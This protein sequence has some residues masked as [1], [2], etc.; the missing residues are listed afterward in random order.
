MWCIFC[1]GAW[2]YLNRI[3]ILY[4]SDASRRLLWFVNS[5]VYR[6]WDPP[7]PPI[8]QRGRMRV[9]I[10]SGKGALWGALVL[11]RF[12]DKARKRVFF[13]CKKQS[14]AWLQ[15]TEIGFF[16]YTFPE[17]IVGFR[18][19]EMSKVPL[20]QRE[21]GVGG[22]G[23]KWRKLRQNYTYDSFHARLFIDIAFSQWLAVFWRD[24][25]IDLSLFNECVQSHVNFKFITPNH[26]PR[27]LN[28]SFIMI[29]D[30]DHLLSYSISIIQ[31]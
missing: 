18:W 14:K 24:L 17:P 15:I 12:P 29:Y 4:I 30:T 23:E 3:Y 26:P 27:R 13:F 22:G 10:I 21:E 9:P 28:F 7:P 16:L 25:P 31:I 20:R 1:Y 6:L 11:G 19:W 5:Y 2:V 8:A